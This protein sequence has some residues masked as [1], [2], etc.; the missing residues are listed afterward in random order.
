M[1][2]QKT[3]VLCGR[4]RMDSETTLELL[5]GEHAFCPILEFDGCV[6]I[7]VKYWEHTVR[8]T[9]WSWA[10]YSVE[11][12]SDGETYLSLSVA[13]QKRYPYS[14]DAIAA[15]LDDIRWFFG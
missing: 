10:M 13:D 8:D 2:N 6:L 3:K 15:A 11:S 4:I 7:A 1:E 12:R 5:Q 14:G 9:Y